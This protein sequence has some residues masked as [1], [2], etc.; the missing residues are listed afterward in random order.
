MQHAVEPV[1]GFVASEHAAGAVRSM[2]AGSEPEN[3]NARLGIAKTRDRLA[4]ILPIAIGPAL[5]GGNVD[6]VIA[7]TRASFAHDNL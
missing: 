7:Q 4:P 6:T 1:A 5:D 2:G 3:E